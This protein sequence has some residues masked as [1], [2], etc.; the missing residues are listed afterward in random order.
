MRR[1]VR[2][3][4]LALVFLGSFGLS[5]P[6]RAQCGVNCIRVNDASDTTHGSCDFGGTGTCSLRDALTKSNAIQGWSI[7]FAIGTGAKT[8]NVLSNLPDIITRGTIDG[9]TQ[10]GYA[11][12]PLIE[13]HRAN[14]GTAANGLHVIADGLVA[15][16]ALVVNHFSSG[17]AI[18]FESPGSNFVESCYIGT[19]A[20]GTTAD[21]NATGILIATGVGGNTIGGLTSD[22]RNVI[23][24]NGTGIYIRSTNDNQVVGNFF[25]T[26]AAGTAGLPNTVAI[27]IANA[28]SASTN[29]VIGG[30]T[31]AARNV[32]ASGVPAVSAW[33]VSL[34]EGTSNRVKGNYLGTDAT[35][36]VALPLEIGIYATAETSDTFANNVIV[37]TGDGIRLGWDGVT[38]TTDTDIQGNRIGTD[39]TGNKLLKFGGGSGVSFLNARNNL[40]GGSAAGQGNVIGGYDYGVYALDSFN[41]ILGNRIGIGVTGAVIP[42]VLAGVAAFA[43]GGNTVV[44]GDAVGEQNYIAYNGRGTPPPQKAPGVWVQSGVGNVVRGN[45]IF[46]NTGKG[47]EFFGSPSASPYPNDLN[48]ADSGPPNQLQNWPIITGSSIVG[49]DIHIQGTIN[50]KP[51]TL[52]AIDFY[53]DLPPVHPADL[54]QGQNYLGLFEPTTNAQGNATFDVTFTVPQTPPAYLWFTATASDPGG[55]PGG[56]TSELSQRSLFSVTPN[57][58]PAT[59]GTSTTLKGQLFQAGATVTF[60]GVPATGVVFTD[61]Q[62]MTAVTP[63]LTPGVLVDVAVTNPAPGGTSA[64]MQKAFVPNFLDVPP[65]SP[66]YSYVMSLVGDG[67]TAGCGGGN[68]CPNNNVTRAQMAVFLLKA[69]YGP[70]WTPPPATGTVFLDVP[71]G[72]FAAAWIEAVASEGISGGCGGGNYC[73]NSN[74]NRQ[75]MAVFLLKASRGSGYLPPACTGV[76]GDVACPGTFTNWIERLYT[77][78]I[79]GGCSASPL[80][81]CPSSSVNRG[82]MAVFVVKTFQIP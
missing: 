79:T 41:T 81:Y 43:A 38:R 50:S 74:V 33:G 55:I 46:M 25:G 28:T 61:A 80:L 57:R 66:I 77:L 19:N 63:P 69:K 34:D 48:D 5:S 40:A 1:R 14:G 64:V 2:V 65:A 51:N 72:A 49:H 23:S 12:V 70:W 62:T 10:P 32:I 8:I 3:L 37:S 11:G 15:I 39:A 52:Y 20:A 82:Q 60:G 30:D 76:F 31:A 71:S 78:G 17:F 7:Q 24:G 22:K 58:G 9:R 36:L 67:V 21:G 35:G 27:A 75:Q 16:K 54:L 45:S 44:G 4:A 59:G 29:N 6:G 53:A 26:N 68:Y 18:G 56:N 13:I 73:P 47:I 42:N